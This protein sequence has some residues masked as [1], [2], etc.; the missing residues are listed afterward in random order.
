[1][2]SIGIV[3]AALFSAEDFLTVKEISQNTGVP[4]DEVL[5]G[6]KSLK[7]SYDK[8]ES[9][10]EILKTGTGYRMVLR[11][12]YTELAT[13]FSQVELTDGQRRTLSL[14]GYNQPVM[15]SEL[16]RQIGPRVY[17][18]VRVLADMGFISRK[19][20]GQSLEL[21]TTTKFAE[22]LGISSNRKEDIR[23]WF[24]D[25]RKH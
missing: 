7:R 25:N 12:E 16:C 3:E 5:S 11:K 19:H 2:N 18:D 20:V 9:A 23:K 6:L 10:I 8:R 15:Q 4:E 24:E 22:Y 21:T 17:D 1:M 14:I 13:G